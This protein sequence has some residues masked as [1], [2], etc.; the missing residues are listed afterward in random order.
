MPGGNTPGAPPPGGQSP[1]S[2]AY[3]WNAP[4]NTRRSFMTALER[5]FCAFFFRAGTDAAARIPMIRTTTDI[6]T[7]LKPAC[8]PDRL[9]G[10]VDSVKLQRTALVESQVCDRLEQID[11]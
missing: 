5:A 9:F 3:A 10:K 4:E 1:C 6:S 7:R 11:L 8:R 2:W